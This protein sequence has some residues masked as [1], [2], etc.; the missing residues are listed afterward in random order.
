MKTIHSAIATSLHFLKLPILLL[1]LFFNFSIGEQ[2]P[3]SKNSSIDPIGG[4]NAN[5]VSRNYAFNQVEIRSTG[6]E[7]RKVLGS[8]KN[9]VAPQDTFKVEPLAAALIEVPIG[10]IQAA[11]SSNAGIGGGS[12]GNE[13]RNLLNP[14]SAQFT[15]GK[16]GA[17]G[18]D[19]QLAAIG[20]NQTPPRA[21][22][23]IG[24]QEA[25][26]HFPLIGGPETRNIGGAEGIGGQ[27]TPRHYANAIPNGGN[28]A[29]RA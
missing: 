7:T 27:Y 23:E 28:T 4:Q 11:M 6:N 25:P 9:K 3:I 15:I 29:E 18:T 8:V 12:G 22:S 14:V 13:R 5:T 17:L 26:R 16:I 24:G 21:L 10:G 19:R 1:V 20:G 2:Q